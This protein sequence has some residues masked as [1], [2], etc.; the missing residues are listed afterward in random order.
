MFKAATALLAERGAGSLRMTDIAERAGVAASSLY[1]RWGQVGG[2]LLEVAVEQLVREHPL[3]DTGSL[4]KDL[5]TWARRIATGLRSR[6]GSALFKVIVANAA[7]T[8]VHAASRVRSMGP[9]LKQIEVML[10][11]ARQR[12]EP[13]PSVMEV[14]D[15]LL[16]PLYLRALF[17]VPGNEAFAEQLA[18]RLVTLSKPSQQAH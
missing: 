14:V 5:Q 16:A 15:F 4:N 8:G 2:L 9:R 6:R 17:G 10:E 7:A 3:P 1:R 11:R 13:T 12:G 18:K